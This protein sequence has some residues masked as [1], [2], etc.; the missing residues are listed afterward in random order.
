MS[1]Q[2]WRQLLN[3]NPLLVQWGSSGTR[4]VQSRTQSGLEAEQSPAG[5]TASH[6]PSRSW[7]LLWSCSPKDHYCTETRINECAPGPGF[8]MMGR[9]RAQPRGS[10]RWRGH[11]ETE[12]WSPTHVHSDSAAGLCVSAVLQSLLDVSRACCSNQTELHY[13][14]GRFKRKFALVYRASTFRNNTWAKNNI[15]Y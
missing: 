7:T 9:L 15:G 5:G 6:H 10:D 2:L 3:M 12:L 13:R 14:N 1:V 8:G 11:G 4:T